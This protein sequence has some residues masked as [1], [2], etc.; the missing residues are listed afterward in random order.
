MAIT[1]SEIASCTDQFSL[2]AP[3]AV[4]GG[5]MKICYL[6]FNGKPLSIKLSDNLETIN[7]PFAPSVFGGGTGLEDRKGIV[8]NIPDEVFDNFAVLEE[9]C[10]T[11]LVE[12]FPNIESIWTSSVKPKDKF[13]SSLKA[14]I[15]VSGPRVAKFYNADNEIADPPECWRQLPCNAV[16]VIRGCYCQKGS[17][18]LLVDCTHLQAGTPGNVVDDEPSPF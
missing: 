15:N 12:H 1:V 16:V 3:T 7:I 6:K 10:R 13:S 14:K 9:W 4:K 5:T 2:S 11:K 8:F 17:I 18:G